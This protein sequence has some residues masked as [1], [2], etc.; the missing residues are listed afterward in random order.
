MITNADL[1]LYNQ[2]P[3]PDGPTWQ[4][5]QI[6]DVFWEDG[7]KVDVGETELISADLT[8][9]LIPFESTTGYLKPVEFLWAEDRAGHFT[10]NNGDL[11]VRG[12]VDFE[13]TGEKGHNEKALRQQHDDVMTI[14][15]VETN[16]F[17]SPNMQH[18]EVTAK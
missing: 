6:E 10:L 12:L 11:V 7:K 4:R 16:D 1:T 8:V 3:G 17:G 15:S 5:T 13:L 9:I 2:I 18:W 14:V